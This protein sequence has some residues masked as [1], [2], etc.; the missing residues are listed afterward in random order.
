M[1]RASR[2]LSGSFAS[3]PA[4]KDRTAILSSAGP[5]WPLVTWLFLT[6]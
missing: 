1:T 4:K 5:T 2:R 3:L 6:E